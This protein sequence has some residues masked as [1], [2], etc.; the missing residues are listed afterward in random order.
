MVAKKNEKKAAA[1][2]GSGPKLRTEAEARL[3]VKLAKQQ[4][5]APLPVGK[6]LH[7]LQVHQ[8]E[9]EM[10]NESL[11]ESQLALAESRDCYVDF[12]DFS[13][14]G[15][16][17]LD[18]R[19]LI[20]EV[21]LTGAAMLGRDRSKLWQHNFSPLV[22]PADADRWRRHFVTALKAD[23]KLICE[24]ALQRPDGL[25]FE[26]RLDCLK[27]VKPGT[28]PVLRVVLT[29]IGERKRAEDKMRELA[30]SL[31]AQ[32]LERTQ[33]LRRLAGQLTMTEER[34]RRIL[35]QDLHDNLGQ[36]LAVIRIRMSMLH[37]RVESAEAAEMLAKLVDLVGQA[38]RSAR[39]IS[40]ELSPPILHTLGFVA[41][42]EWLGEEIERVY[43]IEVEVSNDTCGAPL[44][45]GLQAMLYR[46]VRE[47]LINVA[48]H[49][50]VKRASVACVRDKGLLLLVVSDDGRGFDPHE[51]GGALSGQRSFGLSSINERIINIGGAMDV[52]SSPGNGTTV[53]LSVP[54]PDSAEEVCNDSNSDRR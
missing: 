11:R 16:L 36:I 4:E 39:A 50:G 5:A 24:L 14:V 41:A 43:D 10:Q 35:A 20:N 27:M 6:L 13:P 49:A 7:D 15:Y 1:A 29:D 30:V 28:G 23:T 2:P 45:K 9:L 33:T 26:V 34:E 42:L 51:D 53:T 8:I 37:T 48:K 21:N 12:F 44:G 54:C 3:A 38:E 47:L 17:T 40:M 46:S 18:A 19:G 32:V 22:A 31:E 25:R 52:D